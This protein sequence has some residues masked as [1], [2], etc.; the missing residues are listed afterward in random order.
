LF[1]MT[2]GGPQPVYRGRAGDCVVRAIAIASQKPYQEVYDAIN[3]LVTP[4]SVRKG[5][6]RSSARNGVAG[7]T[8]EKYLKEISWVWIGSACRLHLK[9]EELPPGRLIVRLSRHLCALVDGVIHDIY[10]PD[11]QGSRCVYGY[12]CRFKQGK[13]RRYGHEQ[14][15]SS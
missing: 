3:R 4:S 13:R 2:E 12:L 11:R 9:A 14:R 5:Q 6:R 15:T 7:A 1:T 10:K 8:Y